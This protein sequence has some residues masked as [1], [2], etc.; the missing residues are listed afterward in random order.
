MQTPRQLARLG[1]ILSK[2]NPETAISV[3]DYKQSLPAGG[4]TPDFPIGE[5]GGDG[6]PPGTGKTGFPGAAQNP[7]SG[8][9]G[10]PLRP[11]RLPDR[12]RHQGMAGNSPQGGRFPGGGGK[13]EKKPIRLKKIY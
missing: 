4:R 3:S 5:T 13:N 8:A 9:D 12:V 6:P 7:R 11:R 1:E 10:N 2:E